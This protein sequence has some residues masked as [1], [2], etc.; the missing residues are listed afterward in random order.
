M[1][2]MMNSKYLV[3]IGLTESH[4]G[5]V[6]FVCQQVITRKDKFM[7]IEL[8]IASPKEN[9]GQFF[10][11]KEEK[12]DTTLARQKVS[13]VEGH[14]KSSIPSSNFS[15]SYSVYEGD[16]VEG[17]REKILNDNAISLI[18]MGASQ[19]SLGKG[20]TINNLIEKVNEIM[21]IPF[22]VIPQNITDEQISR[23]VI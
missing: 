10:M 13:S 11:I 2:N 5:A 4:D 8:L 18:I 19:K 7:N 6:R 1:N 15:I 3:C 20:R 16:F 21:T 22:I 23:I 14:I 9:N 17:F 12:N